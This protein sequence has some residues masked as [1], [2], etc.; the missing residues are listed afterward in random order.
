MKIS[1]SNHQGK[2][3]REKDVYRQFLVSKNF[4]LE[5]TESDPID[6]GKTNE[7]SFEE[8]DLN[9][10][11]I[12]KKSWWLKLKDAFFNNLIAPI[13]VGLIL[14]VFGGYAFIYREQGIQGEKI[15]VIENN[16]KELKNNKDN[17]NGTF[18]EEFVI[19]KVEV[20][21]DLEFIKN[22]IGL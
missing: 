20:M 14:I 8:N 4:N 10:I 22:K 21:K 13:L 1:R 5:K 19:F 11:K 18:R 15:T 9:P 16:I 12:S 2:G 6:T 7:S 3:S 17:N